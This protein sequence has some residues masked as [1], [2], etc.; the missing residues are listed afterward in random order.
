MIVKNSPLVALPCPQR[1]GI[2]I[3]EEFRTHQGKTMKIRTAVLLIS[4]LVV[5]TTVQALEFGTGWTGVF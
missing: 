2:L 3:L 5:M 4:L 1:K